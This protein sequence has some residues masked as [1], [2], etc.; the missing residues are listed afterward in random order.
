MCRLET[1]IFLK[2]KLHKERR[3]NFFKKTPKFI[4]IFFEVFEISGPTLSRHM[5]FLLYQALS[6]LRGLQA[7]SCAADAKTFNNLVL[8]TWHYLSG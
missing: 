5:S 7:N 6:D 4:K 2:K 8:M 3:L 1:Y